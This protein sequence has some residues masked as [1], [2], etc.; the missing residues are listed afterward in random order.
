MET[1]TLTAQ[2]LE[3]I[4]EIA[5]TGR[6]QSAPDIVHAALGALAEQER[7]RRLK[8]EIA[9]ARAEHDRGE[10]APFTRELFDGIVAEALAKSS[11]SKPASDASES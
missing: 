9:I 3:L 8:D 1:I 2:D 6:Y 10:G 5:D 7:F 11:P 4:E